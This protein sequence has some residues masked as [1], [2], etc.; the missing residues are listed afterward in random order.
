MYGLGNLRDI[1]ILYENHKMTHRTSSYETHLPHRAPE[2]YAQRASK[3]PRTYEQYVKH[4]ANDH[5]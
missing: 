2:T 1:G 5:Q 3:R 4:A